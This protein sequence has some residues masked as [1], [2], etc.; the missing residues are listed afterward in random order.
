MNLDT[1]LDRLEARLTPPAPPLA[2]VVW[3][4]DPDDPDTGYYTDP[5]GQPIAGEDIPPAT[6]CYGDSM[7]VEAV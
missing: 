4:P 1:R 2:Y 6:K 5:T 3:H 7:D